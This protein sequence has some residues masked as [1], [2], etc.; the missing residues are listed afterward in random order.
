MSLPAT[1]NRSI[2]SSL[3]KGDEGWPVYGLQAGLDAVGYNLAYDGDFGVLTDQAVRNFQT[4]QKLEPDGIAGQITQTRLITLIDAKTHDKHSKLP[5]GLLRGF[6]EAEGGNNVGAVNWQ[7][8]GGVDCGV[9]QIRVYGPPYKVEDMYAAF[10]P[11]VAM[12][13]TAVTFQGRLQSYRE[14]RYAKGQ[15]IEFAQRCA[16]LS[17]NWP[18]AAEEYAKIGKLPNPAKDAT[19]AVVNGKR[20]KFPD[21]APVMTWKDWAEFYAMGGRHGE[22]RVTRY[23]IW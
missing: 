23:C 5:T 6:S 4:K 13:R 20:I 1:P 10:D 16:A 2:P 22:G 9:V 11:A 8:S 17:W 19:W 7:V 14:M 12:D 15:P 18:Y 3:R 21:G